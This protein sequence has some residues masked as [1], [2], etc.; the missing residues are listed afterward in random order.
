MG[1][2]QGRTNN[3]NGRP[4]GSKNKYS[5]EIR[6]LIFDLISKNLE[7]INEDVENLEPKERLK[8]LTSILPYAIPKLQFVTQQNNNPP[9]RE[10][11]AEMF[12]KIFPEENSSL[13][14]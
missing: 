5:D 4:I 8:F 10:D 9:S 14:P 3:T 13:M 2:P 7:T 12:D 1:L 6:S 11:F